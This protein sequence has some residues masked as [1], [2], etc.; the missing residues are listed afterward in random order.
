MSEMI[1]IYKALY[2]FIISWRVCVLRFMQKI[3][4]KWRVNPEKKALRTDRWKDGQ[5][6]RTIFVG[7]KNKY[8]MITLFIP[9]DE[10]EDKLLI[11]LS[12]YKT[13]SK[14]NVEN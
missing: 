3:K 11:N 2:H 10:M 8:N 4:K 13:S 1:E 12:T 5:K 9:F 14:I 6:D 7:S